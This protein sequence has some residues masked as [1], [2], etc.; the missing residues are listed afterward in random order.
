MQAVLRRS[1]GYSQPTLRIGDVV[2]NL[3]SREVTWLAPRSTS[4][5]RN[6]PSWSC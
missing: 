6:T 3:D 5:A 4:R 2:L 1:K